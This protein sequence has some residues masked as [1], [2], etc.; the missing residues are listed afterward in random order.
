MNSALNGKKIAVVGVGVSNLSCLRYLIRHDLRKITL[1][2]TRQQPPRLSELPAGIEVR[3]GELSSAV[4]SE[5]DL[6][7]LGP[8]ISVYCDEIQAAAKAGV[9][10]VGDIELFAREVESPVI[11]ITGSN[12]KSTVTALTTLMAQEA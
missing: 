2:D 5:Y 1:F 6:L 8:G 4:L 12:G 9:E 3:L 10:I 7:V 11:G